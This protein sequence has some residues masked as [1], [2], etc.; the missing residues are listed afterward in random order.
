[1][2]PTPSAIIGLQAGGWPGPWLP[3]GHRDGKGV[4]GLESLPGERFQVLRGGDKKTEGRGADQWLRNWG[5]SIHGG[6]GLKV[7]S[8]WRQQW[9]AERQESS[10]LSSRSG[11]E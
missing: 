3:Q 2:S 10:G 8:C 5:Q 9:G 1:M 6:I 7:P 4:L 11:W